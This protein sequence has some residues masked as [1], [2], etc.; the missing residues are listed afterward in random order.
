MNRAEAGVPCLCGEY[1]C[2]GQ[3]MARE[4]GPGV[5][6]IFSSGPAN[7]VIFRLGDC[8]PLLE[9]KQE[10]EDLTLVFGRVYSPLSI[11]PDFNN[12]DGSFAL[13]RFRSGPGVGETLVL[14]VDRF[15]MRPAFYVH[16][17]ANGVLYFSTH[18]AGIRFLL[19]DRLP[20]LS[21]T[22]L[23]HY[24]HFGFTPS[25][26]TLLTGVHKVPA[27]SS[28]IASKTG[29]RLEHYF[30]LAALYR[31]EKYSHLGEE[32]IAAGIDAE[33]ERSIRLRLGDKTRLALALSG[34]VDSGFVARKA[35]EIGVRV[36]G[37]HLA[38]ENRY[39][40][41]SRVERLAKN[42]SLDIVPLVLSADRLIENMER[43]SFLTSEPVNF[44][45]AA[46]M[47]LHRA[48]QADGFDALWDGDGVD[49]LFF[50]MNRYMQYYKLYTLYRRLEKMGLDRLLIGLTRWM[51]LAEWQ[52]ASTWLQ[53]WRN[54]LPPYPER[55]LEKDRAYN[56]EFEELVFNLA[57]KNYRQIFREKFP[58]DDMILY[59]TFQSVSMCPEIFFHAPADL[60][61][62]LGLGPVSPYFSPG[63]VS[64]AL[65]IP[66][67]LK[68][69]QGQTKYIL[70]LAASKGRAR[71]YWFL[72][73]KGLQNS[74]GLIGQSTAGREW[75]DYHYRALK[76]GP[77]A[78][79][80]LDHLQGQ[81]L[82]P[83]RLLPAHLHLSTFGLWAASG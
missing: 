37:Y 2:H 83:V 30:D 79:I 71:E 31:P 7:L 27:G 56:R 41:F 26:E 39:N 19:C 11:E 64:L 82:E 63:L 52:K 6:Q 66:S 3:V 12:L 15:G 74:F 49:R 58:T 60:Q 61:A 80:L 42:F 81:P 17:P 35:R 9:M 36:T 28:L 8:G 50:G 21:R 18:L 55:R 47:V 44:N 4:L 22:A 16:D 29:I 14:A 53:N 33:L 75:L 43:A 20:P 67:R 73:K 68:V 13:I 62:S 72:P 65:S 1:R 10:G 48:A 5:K 23:I 51:P 76:Q 40:E 38:Y 57:I 78:A 34:G 77:L 32:E 25:Q 69:K 54:G 24:Y 45:D 70:R 59:F 46:L